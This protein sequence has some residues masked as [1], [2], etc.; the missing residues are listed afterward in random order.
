[1]LKSFAVLVM[2][3]DHHIPDNKAFTDMVQSGCAAAMDGS[4]VT[5]G[6]SPDNPETGYGYIELGNS[7]LKHCYNVKKFHEKKRSKNN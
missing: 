2:P 5:F 6:V 4:L 3:S 1:M 7:T